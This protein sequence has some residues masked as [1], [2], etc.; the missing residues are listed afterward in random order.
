M[1]VDVLGAGRQSRA[2]ERRP[3]RKPTAGVVNRNRYSPTRGGAKTQEDNET[4]DVG[5][6]QTSR[7]GAQRTVEPYR[8]VFS[9][10]LTLF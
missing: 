8:I 4:M 1:V 9:A 6:A 10:F 7:T 2:F 3:A 5:Q